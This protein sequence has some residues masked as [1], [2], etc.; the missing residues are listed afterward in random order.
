M[1]I[2]VRPKDTF[3]LA[4]LDSLLAGGILTDPNP[5]GVGRQLI[6][7]MGAGLADLSFDVW[8][9]SQ[10]LY[11]DTATDTDLDRLGLN[12]GLGRDAG[13]PAGDPVTVTRVNGWLED[14]VLPAQI[15]FQATLADNTAI[16]YRSLQDVRLG[17]RGRSVSGTAP[18]TA[19]TGG[20]NDQ[21]GINLDGDGVRTVTLGTLTGGAVI[22]AAIQTAVR[23]LTAL[24]P[25]NQPACTNFLCD[26]GVTSPG[27]YTLRSGTTGPGSSVVVTDVAPHP[28]APVLKLGAL[29]GGTE[30]VGQDS[31]DVPVMADQNGVI[32]NVGAGQINVLL[33]TI[34]GV[35]SVANALPFTN[36]R[37]RA[38]DDAYRQDIR[39]WLQSLGTGTEPAIERAVYQTVGADGLRHVTSMQGAYGAG[40]MTI[41]V[42]DGRSLTVG[43]QEST[44]ADVEYELLVAG[45]NGRPDIP[46]GTTVGVVPALVQP[47]NVR[48]TVV[49]GPTPDLLQAQLAIVATI[50]QVLFGW[51]VGQQLTYGQ[52]T[53]AIDQTVVEVL[54]ITYTDPPHFW[55]TGSQVL[56]AVMGVKYMPQVIQIT[57]VRAT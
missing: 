25:G 50:Y 18:G 32:G 4:L 41:W 27:V 22:A 11:L 54:G 44:R 13:Q 42:C 1:P 40:T 55:A 46:A 35:F 9:A 56:P 43:C 23:A 26:F 53:T 19:L 5:I 34:A 30:A 8:L 38:S 3:V 39:D 16:R 33:T 24:T 14:I 45:V 36:G 10:T 29:H 51:P 6:E 7:G 57:C 48:A 52:L 28:A 31:T 17:P 12:Y 37:E 2:T 47:V 49:L 20:T 15:L 21:L